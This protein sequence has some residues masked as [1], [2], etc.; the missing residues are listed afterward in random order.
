M[1]LHAVGLAPKSH[2]AL[3]PAA[4]H[5]RHLGGHLAALLL[6][7]VHGGLRRA[8]GGGGRVAVGLEAAGQRA[9]AEAHHRRL[10]SPAPASLRDSPPLTHVQ[11]LAST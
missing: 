11:A 9:E 10:L 2:G 6:P 8:R 1:E 4:R 5:L 3:A 7:Q